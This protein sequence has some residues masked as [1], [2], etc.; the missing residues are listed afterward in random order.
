MYAELPENL[1]DEIPARR[2]FDLALAEIRRGPPAATALDIG[3]FRGDFLALLPS[4][5]QK[6]GIEPSRAARHRAEQRGIKIIGDTLDTAVVENGSFDL[7]FMMD[8]AE[9]LPDPFDGLK[10]ISRWL[11]PG[12]RLIVT[13]GNSDALLWRLSR[14]NYWYYFPQH[15]SFCNRRWFEWAAR[16]LDL[17]IISLAKFSHSRRAYGKWFVPERWRQLAKSLILWGLA[18]CG[19][20]SKRF[21]ARGDSTWPDHIFVVL[22]ASDK[23]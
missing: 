10:K 18:R 14:L 22:R 17:E 12:G 20:R 5:L 15:I 2:Y 11:A 16:Q 9:H 23:S 19:Y 4:S 3:C 21:I 13:T 1:L 7:I 6:S 8:V